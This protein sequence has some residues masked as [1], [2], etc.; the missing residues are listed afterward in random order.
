MRDYRKI[1]AWKLADDLTVIVYERTRRF[2]KEEIYG[3]TAQVR[4]AAYSVAANIAEGSARDS[5]KDY[6][7]FLYIARGSLSET[8]YF[9]HLSWRLGYITETERNSLAERVRAV[10]ACM[11]GLIK[12]VE[13]ESG[14]VA[15]VV[16][17]STRAIVLCLARLLPVFASTA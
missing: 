3:L 17:A 12:A 10:F 15:K 14:K 1:E 7:H 8:Q 16:A 2:P 11:H 4:R 5:Q 6:L 13:K 9:L